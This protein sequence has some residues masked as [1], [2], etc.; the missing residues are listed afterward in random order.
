MSEGSEVGVDVPAPAPTRPAPPVDFELRRLGVVARRWTEALDPVLERVQR[1]AR[2]HDV[3]V[4]Y[5]SETLP[6][7]PEGSARLDLE[8]RPVDV[9]I[10]L[11]G[12][13]TFLRASRIVAT[14]GVPV[15]GINAGH[16][17]FLTS[18]SEGDVEATLARVA[19]GDFV[20]DRRF[21]LR[22]NVVTPK[23]EP[24]GSF[25]ALNDF[26]VHKGGM[27][28]V[29]H[30]DLHVGDGADRDEIGSF[31]A[32]G[33]IF[34]TSTGSTAYS[35]S[36]GGPIIVPELECIVVTPI[37]PHTLAVRPLVVP[38]HERI[39]V[40]GLHRPEDLVLTVDGQEG[41]VLRPGDE[42]IVQK[43][44]AAIPLVRFPGQTFFQ[45]L[46]RKLSWAVRSGVGVGE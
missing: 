3:E 40:R 37:C 33:V 6:H 30:L 13:G 46:R 34:A 19:E 44:E 42:V 20:L 1:F 15:L 39:R 17:G 25:L 36:A 10:S 38:S 18:S 16:L 26:V 12:D 32:D 27:A 45:T 7:A 22:A 29:M 8:T 28:R 43:G 5:E 31:A 4:F 23:G 24:A 41:T 11:G 35:M 2:R 14:R 9:V 21:T